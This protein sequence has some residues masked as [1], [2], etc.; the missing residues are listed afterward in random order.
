MDTLDRDTLNA[1]L[2]TRNEGP[3][4]SFYVPTHEV[5]PDAKQGGNRLKNLLRKAEREL[6]ALEWSAKRIEDLLKPVS[7]LIDD[8]L[9]WK[10]QQKGLAILLGPGTL[11]YF[12]LPIEVQEAVIVG[13][14]FYMKPLLRLL[15]HMDR[16]YVLALSQQHVRV[17]Q[18]TPHSAQR[19]EL[20]DAPANINEVLQYDDPQ[21]QVQF[22]T[23][24]P[25]A[26]PGGFRAAVSHGHGGE[27]DE[28]HENLRRYLRAVD[29]SVCKT[30][31]ND[32][33]PLVFA[34]V[35]YLFPIYQEI[36]KYSGLSDGFVE[37]NPESVPDTELRERAGQILEPVFQQQREKDQSRYHELL[38][39]GR[40][41][42]NIEEIVFA[43]RD[44]R[45]DTLFVDADASVPGVI[46]HDANKVQQEPDSESAAEDL[47]DY[48][49]VE[50]YLNKGTIHPLSSDQVPG[51][52]CAAAIFRY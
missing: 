35:D 12:G 41:S 24:A 18:C 16:F 9:F 43:A 14:R 5:G 6:E 31:K 20:P 25:P 29:R 8:T 30:L 2:K 17:L 33:F 21:K 28:R 3:C 37:G 52:R 40:A 4:L 22:H 39:S 38:N 32:G 19:V 47:L 23:E 7:K 15:S 10:H 45:I 26:G 48:A 36:T 44:G 13:K 46:H 50:T 42:D 51:R 49:A 34:G 27:N 11:H 1:L